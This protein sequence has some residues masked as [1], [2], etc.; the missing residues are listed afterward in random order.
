MLRFTC[1]VCYG[2]FLSLQAL[3]IH[4]SHKHK[5]KSLGS[6]LTPAS[7]LF[8][9]LKPQ[10][11]EES[12]PTVA[13]PEHEV[14]SSTRVR[15]KKKKKRKRKKGWRTAELKITTD[16]VSLN[17]DSRSPEY[18]ENIR[19]HYDSLKKKYP[20]LSC[21]DCS[22]ANSDR[23]LAE[24]TFQRW[25]S[26]AERESDRKAIRANLP[27]SPNAESVEIDRRGHKDVTKASRHRFNNA[28]KFALLQ[29]WDRKRAK[30]NSLST[31]EFCAE[32]PLLNEFWSQAWR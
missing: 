17:A 5:T 9:S 32:K 6:R 28:Q 8:R 23:G 21:K 16:V 11:R 1:D 7:P 19:N 25:C 31:I 14:V 18:R 27:T 29:E 2:S 20:N 12:F 22:K 26:P 15:V 4:Q 10:V 24:R 30:N 13:N 3:K